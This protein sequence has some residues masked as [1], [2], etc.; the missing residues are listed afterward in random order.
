MSR[1]TLVALALVAGL[2]IIV[3]LNPPHSVCDSQFL[4]FQEEQTPFL[5]LDKSQAFAKTTGF[6]ASYD[7]CL[8][9]NNL[10]ACAALFTGVTRLLDDLES[11][12]PKCHQSFFK[13][14]EVKKALS[15]TMSLMLRLAWGN[16]PP[17][18]IYERTSWLSRNNLFLFCT[19]ESKY[20]DYY[21]ASNYESWRE[22]QM[23]D[24]PNPKNLDR[25]NI[26]KLSLFSLDCR[27][28]L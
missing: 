28:F 15:D 16:E 3:V 8:N 22:G 4:I 9:G 27:K 21:G 11:G 5:Y 19:L 26:W 20:K 1:A 12:N 24:L 7:R 23:N 10:G 2:V 13:R 25:Q 14:K 17:E 6:K 18:N